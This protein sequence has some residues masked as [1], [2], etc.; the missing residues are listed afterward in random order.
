MSDQDNACPCGDAHVDTC[1]GCAGV[2]DTD[3]IEWWPSGLNADDL[4][5]APWLIRTCFP[6]GSLH[7]PESHKPPEPPVILLQATATVDEQSEALHGELR[8][9]INDLDGD[10]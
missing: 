7:G 2:S 1:Q 4:R 9:R 10:A 8:H 6:D 5:A 3:Y